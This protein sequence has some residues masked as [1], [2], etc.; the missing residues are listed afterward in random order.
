MVFA[1]GAPIILL[2]YAY[3]GFSFDRKRAILA[4]RMLVPGSFERQARLV[5]D[6]REVS[7]FLMCFDAL[8]TNTWSGLVVQSVMNISF[9]YRLLRVVQVYSESRR[10]ARRLSYNSQSESKKPITKE[11]EAETPQSQPQTQARVP[12]VISLVFLAIGITVIVFAHK[13]I[14]H[15][16]RECEMYPE[17]VAFAYRWATNKS[18]PCLVYIDADVAPKTWDEWTNP[19]DATASVS[20]LAASGNLLVLNI[21]NRQLRVWPDELSRCTNLRHM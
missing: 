10:K 3:S 7:T 9:G 16:T 8:R 2:E 14:A 1:V 17:C 12:R 13:A 19:K 11:G 5:A 21:I 4:H 15:S 6:P 20:K 18:C